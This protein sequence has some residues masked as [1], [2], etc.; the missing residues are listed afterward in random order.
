MNPQQPQDPNNRPAYY[1]AN[2]QP[3][4]G[5]PQPVQPQAPLDSSGGVQPQRTS[6]VTA[7]PDQV[8]GQNY[9]PAIRVQYANEP[10]VV[11]ASRSI[12]PE[13]MEVSDKLQQ[14]HE[15]A[16]KRYPHLN[17]SAGEFVILDIIRHPIGLFLHFAAGGVVLLALI[18]VMIVYPADP[19]AFGLPSF[20]LASAIGGLLM[21]LVGLGTFIAVWVYLQ[22]HFYMTNESVIQEI[23][24]SLF[25]RHEQTVSLGSIEDASFKQNG[26][27]QTMFNY[28]TIRL[29][30]EGEETTYRFAFVA[31]PRDQVAT[32][33]NAIESFKNGR[34]VDPYES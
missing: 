32:L 29:S 17:L 33:N 7:A 11:H 3:V 2:G 19:A 27:V 5:T 20:G 18:I 12:E 23:Q 4:Y 30:T 22:N 25:S 26:I 8:Q 28:G 1:D 15:E 14:R 24:H 10:G 16:V 6:H 21:A 34:P 9:D 31:N 13:P